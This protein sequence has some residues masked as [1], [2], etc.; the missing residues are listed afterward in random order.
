MEAKGEI[1]NKERLVELSNVIRNKYNSLKQGEEEFQKEM[2]RKFKPILDKV[3]EIQA[4]KAEVPTP[5][6]STIACEDCNFGLRKS[7]EGTYFLGTYPVT[8]TNTKIKILDREYD[9]TRGLL[10]LLTKKSPQHYTNEDLFQYKAMLIDSGAHL[11]KVQN[12]LKRARGS[13]YEKIILPLFQ[14]Y[15]EKSDVVVGDIP[16]K[17]FERES[18]SSSND[19]SSFESFSENETNVAEN[20]NN[21]FN[22]SSGEKLPVQ[23]ELKGSGLVNAAKSRMKVIKNNNIVPLYTYWDD[24]NELVERLFLLHASR[25]AGNNNVDNEILNIEEELREAGYIA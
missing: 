4:V 17:K 13:K 23:K 22:S 10:E 24:P 25:N 3:E 8:F 6:S 21:T 9:Q 12:R 5:L 18:F 20:D 19:E 1:V 7:R 11:T 16:A 2:S 15:S 14:Y